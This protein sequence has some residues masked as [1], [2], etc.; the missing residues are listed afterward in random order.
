M[1]NTLCCLLKKV[2]G[3]PC[4]MPG[5]SSVVIPALLFYFGE[6]GPLLGVYC[7]LLSS[8][9]T[10]AGWKLL[11]RSNYP[12]QVCRNQAKF[13][14]PGKNPGAV[15]ITDSFSTFFHI[16]IE[17]GED[18][19]AEEALGVY[20][21]VCPTIR[22]TILTAIRK[23]S[24]KLNYSNSIPEIAFPCTCLSANHKGLPLH[25]ATI[26]STGLLTCTED[27]LH[28]SSMTELHHL[29]KG[30]VICLL[31]LLIITLLQYSS[32]YSIS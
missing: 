10:D 5:M 27:P 7:F 31:I 9:I 30:T 11:E 4:L 25:P 8:L 19:S 6:D 17:P 1:V 29:W 26:S 15:T 18:A 14:L 3:L 21:E 16:A 2:E 32:T 28:S 22:E 13:I 12:V 24:R 20:E 23:A